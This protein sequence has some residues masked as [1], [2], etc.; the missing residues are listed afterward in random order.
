MEQNIDLRHDMQV[1]GFYF[2]FFNIK[3][4]NTVKSNEFYVSFVL[5]L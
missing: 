1:F 5:D 4:Q 2:T 3:D